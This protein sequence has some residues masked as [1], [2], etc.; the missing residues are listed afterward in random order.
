M[1]EARI[2]KSPTDITVITDI[3]RMQAALESLPAA[4]HPL[5]QEMVDRR[6]LVKDIRDGQTMVEVALKKP[7]MMMTAVG[8]HAGG[9]EKIASVAM[10]DT[11]TM[12]PQTAIHLRVSSTRSSG[13]N[14]MTPH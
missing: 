14:V 12:L 11:V 7:I 4:S 13:P 2:T 9:C 8:S 3:Q 5:I 6:L 10:I 1:A